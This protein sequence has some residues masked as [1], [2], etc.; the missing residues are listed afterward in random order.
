MSKR[1]ARSTSRC[2]RPATATRPRRDASKPGPPICSIPRSGASRPR[3]RTKLASRSEEAAAAREAHELRERAARV[4]ADPPAGESLEELA[5]W[6]TETRAALYVRRA[7]VAAQ[8]EAAI[9]QAN[10]L[11]SAL[12]GEPLV[13]QSAALV[14]RRVEEARR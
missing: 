6:A 9:R 5:A 10:E 7:Q 11:G 1:G 2:S 12:L 14:A 3:R 4:E 8:R 13:A